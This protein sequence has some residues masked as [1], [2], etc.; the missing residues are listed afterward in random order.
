MYPLSSDPLAGCSKYQASRPLHSANA[1]L[2]RRARYLLRNVNVN[3]GQIHPPDDPHFRLHPPRP[4]RGVGLG[5]DRAGAHGRLTGLAYSL[6]R[7]PDSLP[8]IPAQS[9]S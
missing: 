5:P 4:R 2:E 9:A 7:F 1:I 6:S 3:E 8:L